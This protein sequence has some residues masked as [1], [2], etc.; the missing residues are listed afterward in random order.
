MFLYS[1]FKNYILFHLQEQ[2]Q[3][4]NQYNQ[5]K[6]AEHSSLQAYIEAKKE[7]QLSITK[8]DSATK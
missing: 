5:F 1:F 6:Q 8:G 4:D 3:L 7:Q 2:Q